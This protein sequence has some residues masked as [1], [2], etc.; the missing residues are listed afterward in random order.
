VLT[1]VLL[2]PLEVFVARPARLWSR[3]Q[4]LMRAVTRPAPTQV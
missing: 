2:A 4:G 3:V 1:L